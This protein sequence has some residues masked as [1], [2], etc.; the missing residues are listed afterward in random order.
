MKKFWIVLLS[1]GLIAAFAFPAAAVEVKIAGSYFIQGIYENNR[2]LLDK[3]EGYGGA[4]MGYFAQ[5]LRIEPVF[6][7]AEGL[8][9]NM[10]IDA[11]ERVWG[12]EAVGK[13]TTGV[14][15]PYE[16]MGYRNLQDEQNIQ[17]R[18]V[19]VDF[20]TPYGMFLAG[21]MGDGAW[22]TD[23]GDLPTEGPTIVFITKLGPVVLGLIAEKAGEGRLGSVNTKTPAGY[24][25]SDV[26]KYCVSGNYTWPQGVFQLLYCRVNVNS[27]AR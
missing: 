11:M 13:E 16:H 14:G 24:V 6:K 20:L 27:A 21:Y 2:S 12:Q 22:G 19:W 7:I 25:D 18:R 23:F 26:D 10:R 17:F 8:N 4:S 3:D 1:L 5:R 15:T 9:L